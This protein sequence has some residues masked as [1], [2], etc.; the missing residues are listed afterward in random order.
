MRDEKA[1]YGWQSD[2]DAFRIAK[3]LEIREALSEYIADAS[4]EQR[5]AWADSIPPLQA[6]IEKSVVASALAREYSTILEYMLPMESR[7]PDVIL[8]VGGSIMIVE[9]KGKT[10]PS[11]A[12]LDQVAAYARDLR[13][14]H[15]ECAGREV[16]PVLVPTRAHGD[17]GSRE[18][19]RIVG[20]DTIHAL[21]RDISAPSPTAQL[22]R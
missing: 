5:R 6:E 7:R 10:F 14:Y 15:R 19:V 21:V 3:P 8:L 16:I 2:F 11:Q 17:L 18:G 4:V 22:S 13:N 1:R 20:P 12:D 9:L